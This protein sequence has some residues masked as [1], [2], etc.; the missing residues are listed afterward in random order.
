MAVDPDLAVAAPALN[1]PGTYAL[2]IRLDHPSKIIIG[3]RGRFHFPAGFYLYIGSALGPGGLAGRLARHLRPDKRLHWHVDYLL[4]SAHA[5]VTEIWAATGQERHECDWARAA[6]QMSGAR[7][8][9][10]RFGASDC[11][12][13]THLIAFK[14]VTK[15]GL[16]D[17]IAV[18]GGK[19][20][21][22]IKL[23]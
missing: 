23:E 1:S 9:V 7:A 18:A 5:R 2:L 22:G 15:P 13:I 19:G 16:Y 17:F 14:P 10:P 8:A 20:I 12:C 3:R 4:G 11:R 6:L 21:I